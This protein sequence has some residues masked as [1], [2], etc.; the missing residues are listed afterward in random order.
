MYTSRIHIGPAP[1]AKVDFKLTRDAGYFRWQEGLLWHVPARDPARS[2][3]RKLVIPAKLRARVL[4]AF[5]DF[6][7]HP[8]RDSCLMGI[9]EYA[10][11][12]NMVEDVDAWITK[13]AECTLQKDP[14]KMTGMVQQPERGEAPFVFWSADVLGPLPA[15]ATGNRYVLGFICTFSRFV[16][17]VPLPEVPTSAGCLKILEERIL[18]PYG[19]PRAIYTDRASIFCSTEMIDQGVVR[20][21]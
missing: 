19:L 6:G 4:R 20:L 18:A 7:G 14:K 1:S 21:R 16:V 15:T 2:D 13:C 5:H 9:K 8:G 12:P 17:C 10:W 3:Q 11:W